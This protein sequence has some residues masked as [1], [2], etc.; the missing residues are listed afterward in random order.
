M[1]DKPID[2][3]AALKVASD[4]RMKAEEIAAK[5]RAMDRRDRRRFMRKLTKQGATKGGPTKARVAR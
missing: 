5:V 1:Q 2:S 4:M 3:E